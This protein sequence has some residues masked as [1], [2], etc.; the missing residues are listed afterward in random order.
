MINTMGHVSVLQG[1]WVESVRTVSI[2]S[3]PVWFP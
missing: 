2:S 3:V 1:S